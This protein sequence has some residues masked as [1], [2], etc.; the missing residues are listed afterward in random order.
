MDRSREVVCLAESSS[1]ERTPP[2]SQDETPTMTPDVSPSASC[3]S[4]SS[5]SDGTLNT[6]E[7]SP[8][9]SSVSPPFSLTSSLAFPSSRNVI[10][11]LPFL[12]LMRGC[13]MSGR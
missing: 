13:R 2:P 7:A 3:L 12:D 5:G 9:A 1:P 11:Y 8:G 6:F 4:I 10:T